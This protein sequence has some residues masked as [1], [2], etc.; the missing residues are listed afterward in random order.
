MIEMNHS[1]G[2]RLLS[3]ENSRAAFWPVLTKMDGDLAE[4]ARIGGCDHCGGVLHRADYARKVRCVK[5]EARRNSLCC[6]QESCR[7]RKMPGSV[8]F[9][10]RRVYPGFI[11][12]VLSALRHGLSAER[13]R[14]L[15]EQLG[16]DRRTL[17][18]WRRW[19]LEQFAS[20]RFWRVE[21]ARL[22]TP[23]NK[24]ALPSSLWACFTGEGL[25]PLLGL[26]RFLS[27]WS[28]GAA[29]S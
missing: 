7:R 19:W 12:V 16:V 17:E 25:E 13:V 20:G 29:T 8:R 11:V 9:L 24:E 22:M 26:L 15:R 5:V 10:G 4:Q 2:E 14:V 27:T 3:D 21:R 6:S 18:R 23:V 28:T 1:T